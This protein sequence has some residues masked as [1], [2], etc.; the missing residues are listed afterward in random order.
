MV[1]SVRAR[2]RSPSHSKQNARLLCC[3]P[4][5]VPNASAGVRRSVSTASTI[6]ETE[7]YCSRKGT[8]AVR[9]ISL[10]LNP[11]LKTRIPEEVLEDIEEVKGRILEGA[12][13][14]PRGDF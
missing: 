5:S 9:I 6:A 8:A 11:G 10:I 12:L 7:Q 14:V 1:S 13:P 2:A 4:M 3:Q